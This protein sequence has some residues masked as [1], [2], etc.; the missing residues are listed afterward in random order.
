MRLRGLG[1]CDWG[2]SEGVRLRRLGG[3][4]T[5]GARGCG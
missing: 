4:E 2:G 3:C 1:G 5:E